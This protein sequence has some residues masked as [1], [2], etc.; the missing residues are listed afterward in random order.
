[1]A[2]G[3]RIEPGLLIEQVAIAPDLFGPRHKGTLTRVQ[4]ALYRRTQALALG[5]Q[6]EN[7]VDGRMLASQ[8]AQYLNGV[9]V[10]LS[11]QLEQFAFVL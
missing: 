1:M 3:H 7:L 9:S 4:W 11:G 2:L 6:H 5:I 8:P 10:Q